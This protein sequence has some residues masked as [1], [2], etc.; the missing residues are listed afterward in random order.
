ML[1]EG[2]PRLEHIGM[3]ISVLTSLSGLRAY[4]RLFG[5]VPALQASKLDVTSALK[6]GRT[7]AP[8]AIAGRVRAACC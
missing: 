4:R 5:I 7:A 6:E 2:A 8:K 1:P 3:G